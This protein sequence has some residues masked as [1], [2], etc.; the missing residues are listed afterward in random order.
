MAVTESTRISGTHEASEWRA[1]C[2][3]GRPPEVSR[4]PDHSP[5]VDADPG[6]DVWSSE[7]AA[8]IGEQWLRRQLADLGHAS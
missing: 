5:A 8:Y 6:L 2:P 3:P 1:P 4:Q 7:M